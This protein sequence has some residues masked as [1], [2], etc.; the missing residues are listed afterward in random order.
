MWPYT[1][2]EAAWLAAIEVPERSGPRGLDPHSL[3][4]LELAARRYRAQM[5][6]RLLR[7]A[8]LGLW[9]F[10]LCPASSPLRR[11]GGVEERRISG[12]S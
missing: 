7:D 2:D 6:A 4:A 5:I 9:R 11:N 3:F 8:A 12:S 1:N 10:A